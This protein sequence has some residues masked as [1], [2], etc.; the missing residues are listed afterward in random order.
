VFSAVISLHKSI[1][2][3]LSVFYTGPRFPPTSQARGKGSAWPGSSMPEHRQQTSCFQDSS[4]SIVQR[5][6]CRIQKLTASGTGQS[7]SALVQVL[8]WA[9]IFGQERG[10]KARYLC[11]FPVRGELACREFSEHWNSEER[12][13]LP[14]LLI[15]ANRI[16]RGTISKQRQL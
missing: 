2:T 9:Y 6:E 13:S 14:G 12:A 16:T 3:L 10:P 7:N 15:E 4:E 5:W 11:T 8:F 1:L